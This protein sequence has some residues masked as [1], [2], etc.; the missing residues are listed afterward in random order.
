[1]D[2][3]ESGGAAGAE[4]SDI[5]AAAAPERERRMTA[6]RKRDAVLRLPAIHLVYGLAKRW[7]LGTHHG[8]VSRKH[9]EAYLDEYVFRLYGAS[10]VK[11]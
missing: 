5:G 1:M 8:A 7:L 9:L 2:E 10:G 4:T 6:G 11:L 3:V